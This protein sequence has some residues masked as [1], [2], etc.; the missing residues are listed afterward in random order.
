MLDDAKL[1]PNVSL[2]PYVPHDKL[3]GVDFTTAHY[4]RLWAYN[5]RL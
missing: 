1:M 4:R 2:D 3:T 5:S